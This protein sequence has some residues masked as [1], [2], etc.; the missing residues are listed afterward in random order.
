M[1]EMNNSFQIKSPQKKF[2]TINTNMSL[3]QIKEEL[4]A[5]S[6]LDVMDTPTDRERFSKDAYNYSPLLQKQLKGCCADL[7]VRPKAIDAV[8]ATSAACARNNIPLTIRGAGTGNYGQ[9]VPLNGGVVMLM[10][11]LNKIRKFDTY[12][13]VVT[14]ETGCLLR[15]LDKYLSN[16]GRQL[17]LVP[18]T[19]RTASVGGFLAGGSGGIGSIRW[20][21]LRDPGHLQGLEV[22][23][24]QNPPQKLHLDADASEALNHAYGTNGIIT[25]LDLATAPAINWQEATIDCAEWETAVE[26]MQSCAKAAI[27]LNLCSLLEKDIVNHLPKWCGESSNNH[28][29]MLLVAPDGVTTLQRLSASFGGKFT[30]IG[31]EKGL[32][33]KYLRELTWNHTTMHM[34]SVDSDWT[35]LQMLLPKPEVSAMDKL[36]KDW[37][38][39]LLW[40]LEAVHQQGVKRLAAL[41]L[42]KWRGKEYLENLIIQCKEIGCVIFNPHVIT[43]EDG[44]LGVIDSDQ[45][46]TKQNFDPKGLLNPG[47]LKGWEQIVKG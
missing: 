33:G 31:A 28:R 36:K 14:V 38:N 18:S 5:L 35:Y 23:T 2:P 6:D 34:R 20:G 45:V 40:H 11:E 1:A 29:I 42:V 41:P 8:I 19:W 46:K 27:D 4:T 17:R 21:F 13:G 24:L 32:G 3:K 9:C 39:D 47:K 25:A 10:S 15:E 30:L 37:G 12:T 16:Y 44:G 7:V 26:L 22:V 43:V